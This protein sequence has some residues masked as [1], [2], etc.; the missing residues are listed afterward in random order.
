[1]TASAVLE[2]SHHAHQ[3]APLPAVK[4]FVVLV[5]SV[6][7]HIRRSEVSSSQA[8]CTLFQGSRTWIELKTMQLQTIN[9]HEQN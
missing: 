2:R 5:A 9:T 4:Q 7:K 3:R 6:F 8:S 1:M